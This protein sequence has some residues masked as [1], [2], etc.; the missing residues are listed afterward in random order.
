MRLSI[1]LAIF[2]AMIF[3]SLIA[4]ANVITEKKANFRINAAA[5]TA[6]NAALNNGDFYVLITQA[7]TIAN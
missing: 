5:I 4:K 3:G 2:S 6:S 1:G 7:T